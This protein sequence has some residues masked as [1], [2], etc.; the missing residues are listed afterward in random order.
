MAA[1]H[2]AEARGELTVA[3]E[4]AADLIAGLAPAIHLIKGNPAYAARREVTAGGA[5]S[6]RL[7]TLTGASILN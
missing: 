4:L 7:V 5:A 6:G 1:L 2:E 3:D